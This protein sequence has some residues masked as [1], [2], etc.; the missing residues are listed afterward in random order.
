MR[1]LI[2]SLMV[3]L[4][5]GCGTGFQV[6]VGFVAEAPAVNAP[7]DSPISKLQPGDEAPIVQTTSGEYVQMIVPGITKEPPP[8]ITYYGSLGSP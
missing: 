5:I 2:Y 4:L 6:P 3:F 8:G 7:S 1:V